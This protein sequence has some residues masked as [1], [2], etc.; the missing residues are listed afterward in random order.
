MTIFI[1]S[2]VNVRIQRKARGGGGTVVYQ[3]YN[4]FQPWAGGGRGK[5]DGGYFLWPTI[6]ENLP[7]IEETY[8]KGVDK[9]LKEVGLG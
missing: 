1:T 2:Q 6:R 9:L 5:S 7:L 4:Q 8:L 3:G